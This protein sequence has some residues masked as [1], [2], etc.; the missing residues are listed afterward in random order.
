MNTKGTW[1]DQ[2][3]H[4]SGA[5]GKHPPLQGLLRICVDS[6]AAIPCSCAMLVATPRPLLSLFSEPGQSQEC[7]YGS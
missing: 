7:F 2:S 5:R 6:S 4:L 1:L 3:S